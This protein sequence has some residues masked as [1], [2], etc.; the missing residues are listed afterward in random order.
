[1]SFFAFC[2]Q[3]KGAVISE[4]QGQVLFISSF[5]GLEPVSGTRWSSLYLDDL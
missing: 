4:N 3:N 2:L 1:M 5:P